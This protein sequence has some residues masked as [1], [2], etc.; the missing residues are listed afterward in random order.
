MG[1]RGGGDHCRNLGVGIL[2]VGML[3]VYRIDQSGK[4]S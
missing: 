1:F 4:P 2:R 3:G